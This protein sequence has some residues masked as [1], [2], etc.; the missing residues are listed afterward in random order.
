MRVHEIA[1]KLGME[2]RLVI[3][4]L[5]R[6]GIQVTS[7]SN[8]VEDDAAR[9]AM[10]VLQGKVE[11]PT[12]ASLA[13]GVARPVG[14]KKTVGRLLKKDGAASK[15]TA[16]EATPEPKK[17]EKKHILIKRKK[18]EEE[19]AAEAKELSSMT[20]ESAG[21]SVLPDALSA[22]TLGAASV[23]GLAVG[24]ASEVPLEA[25]VAA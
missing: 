8:A 10:D 11:A 25:P 23:G 15:R 7:H 12:G 4:E 13:E 14:A 2:S 16:A 9:W 1:K 22:S 6:L 24:G 19:L 3:P 5:V 17:P 18:T 21:G 20:E